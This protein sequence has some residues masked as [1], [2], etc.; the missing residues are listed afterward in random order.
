MTAVGLVA[1]AISFNGTMSIDWFHR[2][3]SS[4]VQSRLCHYRS[5]LL[6]VSSSYG[7]SPN[8]AQVQGCDAGLNG[9]LLR[10]FFLRHRNGLHSGHPQSTVLLS[11]RAQSLSKMSINY[12]RATSSKILTA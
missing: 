2:S 12:C 11:R 6:T 4:R 5:G 3:F 1:D 10:L 7:A 8:L 9:L